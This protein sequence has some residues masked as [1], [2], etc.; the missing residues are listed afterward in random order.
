M[1]TLQYEDARVRGGGRPLHAWSSGV[2]VENSVS[3]GETGRYIVIKV[4]KPCSRSR[5]GN[6]RSAGS[7]KTV[8]YSSVAGDFP[9]DLH[10]ATDFKGP[11]NGQCAVM[12]TVAAVNSL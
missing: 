12:A 7:E 10:E 8:E 9:S 2:L 3:G 4:M 5:S 6:N 11:V 1:S